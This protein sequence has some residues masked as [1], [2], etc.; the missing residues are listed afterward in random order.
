[1]TQTG[2]YTQPPYS[3]VLHPQE[4]P[5]GF[6]GWDSFPAGTMASGALNAPGV[7]ENPSY[8]APLNNRVLINHEQLR[9]NTGWTTQVILMQAR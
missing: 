2:Y 8:F 9:P 7:G 1:M 4:I 6:L 3:S 5:T